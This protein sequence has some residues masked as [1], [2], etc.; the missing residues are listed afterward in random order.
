MFPMQRFFTTLTALVLFAGTC[1]FAQ[2]DPLAP[3][4]LRTESWS[5]RWISVP[6]AGAQDYG[7]YYFRKDVELAAV[8]A[9]YVVHVTGDTRY[10]L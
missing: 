1:A 3:F 2:R 4:D 6:G 9:D 7:V 5:A 10:K 8:P